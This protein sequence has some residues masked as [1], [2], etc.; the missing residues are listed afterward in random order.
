MARPC[1]VLPLVLFGLGIASV[2]PAAAAPGGTG[3]SMG[4][5]WERW[6]DGGGPGT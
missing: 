5:D 6:E 4:A 1:P 2:R 3:T